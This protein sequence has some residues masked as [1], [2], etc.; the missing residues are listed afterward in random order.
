MRLSRV[1]THIGRIVALD[2]PSLFPVSFMHSHCPI[3]VHCEC[4]VTY[5]GVCGSLSPSLL[6]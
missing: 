5:I 1:V 4:E 6:Y 3:G 2:L